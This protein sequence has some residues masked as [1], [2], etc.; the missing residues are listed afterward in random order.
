MLRSL[1][2]T[3]RP[4]FTQAP[5]GTDESFS[6]WEVYKA[7]FVGLPLAEVTS[8]W[9]RAGGGG[10]GVGPLP[11]SWSWRWRRCCQESLSRWAAL[12]AAAGEGEC[13]GEP[14]EARCG[15]ILG[16]KTQRWRRPSEENEPPLEASGTVGLAGTGAEAK[17]EA[18][19][20]PLVALKAHFLG[21]I[22]DPTALSFHLSLLLSQVKT[23][24]VWHFV[25]EEC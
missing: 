8:V 23:S 13:D 21:I 2:G 15:G 24:Y 25:Q 3:H 22:R 6:D 11:E 17:L 1:L 10:V 16:E 9:G 4:P 20:F 5:S 18:T 14:Q 19:P 12:S 7:V